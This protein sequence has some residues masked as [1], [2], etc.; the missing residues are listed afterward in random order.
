MERMFFAKFKL[1]WLKFRW[2][3]EDH[4]DGKVF[5]ARFLVEQILKN[6]LSNA[7]KYTNTG[8]VEVTVSF[9]SDSMGRDGGAVDSN[10]GSSDAQPGVLTITVS[11][12]GA[13]ISDRNSGV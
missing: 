4:R 12:T 10:N 7:F 8:G 3:M 5:T 2:D 13:G 9:K 11:D 6:L 1:K